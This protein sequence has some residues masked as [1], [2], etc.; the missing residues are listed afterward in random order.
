MIAKAIFL[1]L[2]CVSVVF[3]EVSI[4]SRVGILSQETQRNLGEVDAILDRAKQE[5]EL[6]SPA[7]PPAPRVVAEEHTPSVLLETEAS[8]PSSLVEA[9]TSEIPV[10][11]VTP[12]QPSVMDNEIEKI[13]GA[14]IIV[15]GSRY[16]NAKEVL[17]GSVPGAD[18]TTQNMIDNYNQKYGVYNTGGVAKPGLADYVPKDLVPKAHANFDDEVKRDYKSVYK[19]A[20]KWHFDPTI[21]NP[22][23]LD[24]ML[25]SMWAKRWGYF[26]SQHRDATR[27][28]S[29]EL[30][31]RITPKFNKEY[32]EPG[33]D[34]S[35]GKIYTYANDKSKLAPST[36]NRANFAPK[37]F[38]YG[39]NVID[40]AIDVT[41][42]KNGHGSSP[43]S[44]PKPS[45]VQS[46]VYA[47]YGD[48]INRGSKGPVTIETIQVTAR[49]DSQVDG[50]GKIEKLVIP[51]MLP[52]GSPMENPR[53]AFILRKKTAPRS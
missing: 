12:K 8:G 43:S 22:N 30:V 17:A 3:A 46:M 45:S 51:T 27:R 44:P 32:V 39:S 28:K 40:K 53:K 36:P 15:E 2:L 35:I 33:H 49:K 7:A 20:N 25:G 13:M 50:V 38:W 11:H 16:K 41:G 5:V 42:D 18:P 29:K 48:G 21:D 1:T 52:A 24:S 4:D 31:T 37:N 19:G 26:N 23:T 9:A 6:F 47:A 14:Q 34:S 10:R